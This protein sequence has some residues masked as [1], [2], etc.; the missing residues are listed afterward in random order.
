MG[1]IDRADIIAHLRRE[2]PDG[3][4]HDLAIY[5]DA[6]RSYQA[7]ADNIERNGDIVLH[8]RTGQPMENPYNAI[9]EKAATALRKIPISVGNLWNTPKRWF[10]AVGDKTAEPSEEAFEP[11][12][13]MDATD[14]A[15]IIAKDYELPVCVWVKS[16]RDAPASPVI[17]EN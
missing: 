16:D 1:Q 5:A 3:H 9:R 6:F 14:A 13:A 7:A 11:V 4:E 15:D 2:N 12:L 10:A 8:P 17:V